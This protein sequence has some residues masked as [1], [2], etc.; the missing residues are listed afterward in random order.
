MQTAAKPPLN[1]TLPSDTEIRMTREF[2]APP[3][4]VFEAWTTPAHVRRWFVGCYDLEMTV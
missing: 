1:I 2:N 3:R 4:L